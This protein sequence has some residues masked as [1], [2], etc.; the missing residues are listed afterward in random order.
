[1][2]V[3]AEFSASGGGAENGP[4]QLTRHAKTTE[5]QGDDMAEI[6]RRDFLIKGGAGA[7]AVGAFASL[8]ALGRRIDATDSTMRDRSD[9]SVAT[10][11]AGT[12][13]SKRSTDSLVAYIPDPSSGE[14][15]YMIGTREVVHK[16]S[17]LVARMLRD[18]N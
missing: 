18:A 7:V 3:V 6:S 2:A 15:H 14:I 10:S 17:D 4:C 12:P 9:H 1:M 5:L 16:D 11:S 13:E 8:P